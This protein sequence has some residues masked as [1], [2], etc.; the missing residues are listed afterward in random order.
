MK[1]F[2]KA[3]ASSLDFLFAIMVF[4]S[5]I[6]LYE[7]GWQ[8]V[9]SD[10]ASS[11]EELTLRA[12]SIADTLFESGGYPEDWTPENVSVIGICSDRNVIDERRLVNLID[13]MNSNYSRA[14]ELF[15]LG[16]EEI[17]INITDLDN[18]TLYFAGRPGSMGQPPAN[19]QTVVQTSSIMAIS[20]IRREN[21]SF[22]IY[23]DNSGTMA[24]LLPDNET[25]LGAMQTAVGVFLLRLR[26]Q[27]EIGVT[28]SSACG[29][30]GT[31]QEFTHDPNEVREAMDLMVPGG[32][33]P[34]AASVNYTADFINSSANNSHRV[35]AVITD[36]EELCA[37]DTSAAALYAL[38]RGVDKVDTIGLDIASNS[39]A[40]QQL[41][42]MARLGHG[43]YYSVDTT[44]ELQEAL[45]LSYESTEDKVVVKIAVWR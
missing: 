26:A 30:V 7:F 28:N 23:A 37:G 45:R 16:A 43:K 29:S 13:L 34:L 35:L 11:H 41:R 12:Y 36:G 24:T 44:W 40:E 27:D 14:K 1:N 32:M 42:E 18:N 38:E 3:Q 25:R 9:V 17:Y 15:G 19:Q 8:S 6:A 21:T 4:F 20:I 31:A 33:R 39:T 2:H 5:V 10:A 22:A